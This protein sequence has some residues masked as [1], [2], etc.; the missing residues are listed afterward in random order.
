MSISSHN[1][2]F[3]GNVK[4]YFAVTGNRRPC[5]ICSPS[6]T[7]CGSTVASYTTYQNS[8]KSGRKHISSEP[9]ALDSAACFHCTQKWPEE[10]LQ[11]A[12]VVMYRDMEQTFIKR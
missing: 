9:L 10:G 1:S 3:V 5:F 6:C 4:R 8:F 7:G 12:E 2:L 11:R